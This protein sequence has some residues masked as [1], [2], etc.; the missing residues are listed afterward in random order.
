[1][2]TLFILVGCR[3][4]QDQEPPQRE[5]GQ[6]SDR[7]Q[8]IEAILRFGGDIGV[9]KEKPGQPVVA[10]DYSN[11]PVGDEALVPVAKVTEL[12]GLTLDNTRITDDG[13]ANVKNLTGLAAL[14][15]RG[16]KITDKG[17]A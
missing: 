13:L 10:I 2:P 17:L 1:M 12:Y 5:A 4:H 9:D 11:K 3:G 15:L 8:A 14:D 7:Q 16:V 6:G